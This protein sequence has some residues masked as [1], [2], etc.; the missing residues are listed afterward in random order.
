MLELKQQEKSHS[1]EE[2]EVEGAKSLA[3]ETMGI[4]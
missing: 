3:L 4:T 2:Q 1:V